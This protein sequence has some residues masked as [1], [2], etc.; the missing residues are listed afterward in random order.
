MDR[1]H[2]SPAL[3][4][5]P[6]VPFRE[7]AP[8]WTRHVLSPD[9]DAPPSL[10]A[11]LAVFPL[12][13]IPWLVCYEFIVYRGPASHAFTTYLPGE[14]SWPIWQWTEPLYFSPYVFVTLAPFL[15]PTGR[16]LR[17]FF[18][19]G[20]L[21]TVL[22]HLIFMAVPAIAPP[23]PFNPTGLLGQMM[24]WER[25]MDLNNGTAACP[26]F[27]VFWA[28][29]GAVVFAKRFPRFRTFFYVWAVVVSASCIF[30]GMHSLIDVIAGLAL[31]F[32]TYNYPAILE[33]AARLFRGAPANLAR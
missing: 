23:R 4:E 18:L 21:A 6:A 5:F 29:L 16:V 32:L 24:T 10:W 28:F 20:L 26:S 14:H 3:H 30:T 1:Y 8:V 22:G 15:A 9:D 31:F 17:R 2:P 27:H 19:V 12:V 25:D 11:R 13:F 33:H 7:P